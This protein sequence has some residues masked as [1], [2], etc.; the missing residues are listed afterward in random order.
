[1]LV[2][3]VALLA[4]AACMGGVD[5]MKPAS[6][7]A[8]QHGETVTLGLARRTV[9]QPVDPAV[10]AP[11]EVR[12]VQ[13]TIREI[14]NPRPIRIMFEVRY[15]PSAGNGVLLGA[16]SPFPPDNPGTFMVPARD[17]VRA[18]G[19]IVLTMVVLDEVGPDDRLQVTL[20]GISLRRE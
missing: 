5:G 13:V 1:M 9:R 8:A 12:F 4:P 14:V 15:R 20:D 16:F 7:E 17:E 3:L 11:S 18:G 19:S 6:A 2:T 10:V